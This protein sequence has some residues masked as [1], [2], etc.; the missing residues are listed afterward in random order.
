VEFVAQL[1]PINALA[2]V[3]RSFGGSSRTPATPRHP[4]NDDPFV[5][6]N[7]SVWESLAALRDYVYRPGTSGLAATAPNGSR[8]WISA[9]RLWWIPAGAFRPLPKDANASNTISF[10]LH[11]ARLWFSKLSPQPE[12]DVISV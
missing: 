6:V 2:N 10:T 7:M 12:G 8:K 9:L 11:A 3:S 4:F 5:M 1:D